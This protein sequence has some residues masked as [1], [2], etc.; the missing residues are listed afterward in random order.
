M[1]NY[2]MRETPLAS[3]EILMMTPPNFRARGGGMPTKYKYTASD[4]DC[5]YCVKAEKEKMPCREAADCDCFEERL[6]ADCW[7][8]GQL[9]GC[10]AREI[11]ER[12]LA[13]RVRRL[14]P[15]H[16]NFPF[17][18]LTHRRR[19]INA[20]MM[21]RES[22]P[23]AAVFLLSADSALWTKSVKTLRT[24]GVNFGRITD[25][26]IDSTGRALLQ[27][28]KD[29]YQGNCHITADELCDPDLIG[30]ELIQ[31]LVSAFVIRRYGLSS[32]IL[33]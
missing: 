24:G 6:A 2:F 30:D 23:L 7:T 31:L 11:A 15:P 22:P 26:G 1:T 21:G 32:S 33:R 25:R 19:M 29:L 13:E 9:A 5:Q 4:C 20:A 16:T 10:L 3:L 27:T 14:L 17:K 28:A 12:E 8:H 18:N